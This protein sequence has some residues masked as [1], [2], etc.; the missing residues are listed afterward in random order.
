VSSENHVA[1]ITNV[2]LTYKRTATFEVAPNLS[3]SD[4]RRIISTDKQTNSLHSSVGKYGVMH[5]LKVPLETREE[6][7]IFQLTVTM[8][9][10]AEILISNAR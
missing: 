5:A 1:R 9:M 7:S 3:I 8:S 2:C 4:P 6:Q 10:S